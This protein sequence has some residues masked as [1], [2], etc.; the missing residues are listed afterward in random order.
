[1]TEELVALA[2][3]LISYDTSEADAVLEAAG[4]VKGW[5]EARGIEATHE[6]VRGLPVLKAE[7]GAEE[8]PT[9]ILHGH[10]DV[11]PG[12]P[13]QFDPRIEG[14]RLYG[15][16]SY[17]M[18]GALAAML[19]TTAAMSDQDRVRVR[20]GIVGDEE[21]EEEAERGS[22]RLVDGGF[23]GDF[24]ITG[25]P[26]DLQIGVEAKGVLALRLEV[27]GVAAH[28]AT[29]WLGD[30]AAL[31]AV[32]VFRSIESLPFARQSSE[33]FDRPSINL[34]RILGGDALNKVP[35]RCA[36]DVDIRYLPDQ[37]PAMILDQVR[38]LR[39]GE[40]TQLFTRPPAVVDRDLPYVRALRDAASA[41]HEG[42]RSMSVG[43]D[44][45]SDAV[46][47]LRVG[48]PA[49]EFGPVGDGHHGPGEW[50]SV[51]SLLTYRQTLESFLR[52]LP[53][54]LADD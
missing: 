34:G 48:V 7:V 46:S 30:N 23:I 41:H 1:M 31:R 20:L 53:E 4:F 49:V 16:G 25:E 9:V 45:A 35:D 32:E 21:S 27:A 38:G 22:D 28:G 18:K 42:G 43:R 33:L 6:E 11:V 36:I 5:L 44:G 14:D 54:R 15:R 39:D 29:P 40:V 13:G 24:A 17:D 2:E 8:G 10:L 50:V 26:T 52:A 12:R 51:S 37:D 3:R 47:F 19:V